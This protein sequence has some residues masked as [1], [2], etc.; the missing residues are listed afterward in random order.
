M[1]GLRACES[2]LAYPI[3]RGERRLRFR[4]DRVFANPAHRGD[5]AFRDEKA[6]SGFD[7]YFLHEINRLPDFDGRRILPSTR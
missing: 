7:R 1:Q 4:P 6:T 3:F 5:V 2:P